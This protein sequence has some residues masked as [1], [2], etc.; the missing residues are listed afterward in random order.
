MYR[1]DKRRTLPTECSLQGVIV[2]VE[3]PKYQ[4]RHER[5]D[6]RRIPYPGRNVLV[7]GQNQ[8]PRDKRYAPVLAGHRILGKAVDDALEDV[9]VLLHCGVRE[10]SG[11]L[12]RI[13]RSGS[14]VSHGDQFTS[15]AVPVAGSLFGGGGVVAVVPAVAVEGGASYEIR[16]GF[17][18]G[19]EPGEIGFGALGLFAAVFVPTDFGG[20]AENAGVLPAGVERLG[21]DPLLRSSA[22]AVLNLKVGEEFA[23]STAESA[24]RTTTEGRLNDSILAKV[25]RNCASS[26]A[27]A[28]HL[29]GRTFKRRQQIK[30]HFV[31]VTM[32]L[33]VGYAA[34]FRGE[35]L[36][37]CP[38][39][40][41]L[42]VDPGAARNFALEAKRAG[43]LD[44]RISDKIVDLQLDRLDPSF[45]PSLEK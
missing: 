41:V 28:G 17:I 42:D 43:L 37:N 21:G 12:L 16:G 15:F 22:P 24:L 38:W 35:A 26:W 39:I 20:R 9:Q 6:R 30:P 19:P 40:R 32:A 45:S 1:V 8:H 10:Q 13:G 2:T 27:Q 11:Q 18:P 7:K 3:G 25:V 14:R 34:G 36:F 44:L 4:D 29:Q 5:D 33:A 31:S 23:R